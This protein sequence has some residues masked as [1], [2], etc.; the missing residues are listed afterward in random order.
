VQSAGLGR[1]RLRDFSDGF[2]EIV[3]KFSGTCQPPDHQ[4][5]PSRVDEN[6]SALAHSLS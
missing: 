5:N 4:T 6:A 1:R 3:W 2:S